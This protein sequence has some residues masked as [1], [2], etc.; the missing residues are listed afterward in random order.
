MTSKKQEVDESFETPYTLDRHREQEK[1]AEGSC[2]SETGSSAASSYTD[3][4]Y[5]E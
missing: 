4:D 2:G 3:S 5:S 1:D